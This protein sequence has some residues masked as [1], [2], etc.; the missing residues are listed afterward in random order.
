MRPLVLSRRK[1]LRG[2][3]AGAVVAIGLP[4]LEAML[5]RHGTALGDGTPLPK[6]FG[7][8]FWGNGVR[9]NHWTPTQTGANWALTPELMPFAKVKDDVS[10]V[11]GMYD[12]AAT[13]GTVAHISSLIG[14][15]SGS[16]AQMATG[17]FEDYL[18]PT[19]DQVVAAQIGMTPRF[20]SL[21][22]GI[23]RFDNADPKNFGPSGNALSHNGPDSSNPPIYDPIA[24]Y[25]RVFGDGFSAPNAR[26]RWRRPRSRP[27][28][29]CSIWLWPVVWSTPAFTTPRRR[30]ARAPTKTR[31]RTSRRCS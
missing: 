30:R 13:A 1:L 4:A 16:V 9:L 28:R 20:K 25:N 17:L 10:I 19:M 27:A 29:A 31:A 11:S 5:N 21:E 18:H 6:R 8:F 12:Y 22:F 2:A 15:M 3:A 7:V 23:S 14:V 24:I 26:P